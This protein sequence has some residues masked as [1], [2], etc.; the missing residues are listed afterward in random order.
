M[1]YLLSSAAKIRLIIL[2]HHF[3]VIFG[4]FILEPP[5]LKWLIFSFLSF[6]IIGKI[7]LDIGYHR[8][9]CHRS[10]KTTRPIEIIL[11]LLGSSVGFGST[12][13]WVGLHRRHHAYTD[14]QNDPHSP[15]YIKPSLVW[16]TFWKK[17]HLSV[18]E[19]KDLLKDPIHRALHKHYFTILT[20]VYIILLTIDPRI[21]IWGVSLPATAIF[22][23]A[24]FTDVLGHLYGYRNFNTPDKS[25]NS[26][27]LQ[28][29]S[30][31]TQG[32]HNNHHAYPNKYN[33]SYKWW[34][35]DILGLF[36]KYFLIKKVAQNHNS[37][38]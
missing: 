22:H 28:I 12:L 14:T 29:L 13:G 24:G 6:I 32:L 31:G 1:K 36:I 3:L 25:Q 30:L 37:N 20:S 19:I 4:L 2:L 23:S 38:L 34:E 11:L 33:Y 9:F 35:I 16:L 7:G 18:Y 27:T 15:Q 10:F 21:L 26:L 17:T 5:N 8:Y